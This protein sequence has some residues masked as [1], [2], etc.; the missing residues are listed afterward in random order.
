MNDNKRSSNND[1][2]IAMG[3]FKN[4]LSSLITASCKVNR[5]LVTGMKRQKS[6]NTKA[7]FNTK[8]LVLVFLLPGPFK[9]CYRIGLM[10]EILFTSADCYDYHHHYIFIRIETH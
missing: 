5:N 9:L 6:C 10:L 7:A 3:I 1:N 8:S 2:C 4:N